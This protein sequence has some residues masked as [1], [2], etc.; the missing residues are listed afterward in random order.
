MP[1]AIPAATPLTSMRVAHERLARESSPEFGERLVIYRRQITNL[2]RRNSTSL[3][4]SFQRPHNL[5]IELRS[6]VFVELL[7]SF[8]VPGSFAIDAVGCHCFVCVCND[9]DA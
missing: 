9:E 4:A 7:D 8:V 6:F 3:N 1:A 2:E 5:W